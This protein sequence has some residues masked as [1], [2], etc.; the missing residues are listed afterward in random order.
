M[1]FMTSRKFLYSK[2]HAH[3]DCFFYAKFD[4]KSDVIF[5]VNKT[6]FVTS[7]SNP[8][9]YD[10]QQITDVNTFSTHVHLRVDHNCK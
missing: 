8:S 10:A 9:F 2:F 4:F 1:N 3:F 7:F 6:S 5:L